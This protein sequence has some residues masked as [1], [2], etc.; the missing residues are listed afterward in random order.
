MK[1]GG[2]RNTTICFF[3]LRPI[4]PGEAKTVT[5]VDEFIGMNFRVIACSECASKYGDVIKLK[6][7]GK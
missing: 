4:K 5:I 7:P 2:G 1:S 6:P 3:C